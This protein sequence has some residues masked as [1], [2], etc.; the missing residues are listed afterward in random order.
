MAPD[1]S[2]NP[3]PPTP[4]TATNASATGTAAGDGG[5]GGGGAPPTLEMRPAISRRDDKVEYQP[6]STRPAWREKLN[7][8][9]KTFLW[10]APLTAL[11][12]IYA[13]RAQ[14]ATLEQRVQIS[15]T[16]AS[17][18][19]VATLLAPVD[20][21]VTLDLRAPRAS[22]DAIRE[23]ITNARSLE[24][25]IPD[26]IG[27]E[28]QGD[29]SLTERIERHP[30]FQEWAVDVERS[31]PAIARIRVEPKESR[32]LKLEVKP[33][34]SGFGKVAF[35]PTHVKI[36]GPRSLIEKLPPDQVA[37][38]DLDKLRT[39]GPGIR[40]DTVSV[41]LPPGYDQEG[42]SK[43]PQRVQAT[44]EIKEGEKEMLPTIGIGV[45]LPS[46][47]LEN[48]PKI[49]GP[50]TLPNVEVTGPPA[51]VARVRQPGGD[52]PARVRVII[53][54]DDLKQPTFTKR[55][56]AENYVLPTG[57]TV[58]NPGRDIT[59]KVEPR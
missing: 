26:E 53:E 51:Q 41:L 20:R 39:Y 14:I 54:P 24:I 25:V 1:S 47:L 34:N 15:V 29:I 42:V 48:L 46:V 10:V 50:R 4:T 19:R 52:F 43:E 28:F 37:Y 11:I 12:W 5:G 8:G 9:L 56:T 30:L 3:K 16:S 6:R 23:R 13:E 2:K 17:S 49:I 21:S 32:T 44:V 22:L 58:V 27:P 38:T 59:F 33:E 7:D 55:V 57:V 31:F 45:E 18:D 36:S 35:E 40:T